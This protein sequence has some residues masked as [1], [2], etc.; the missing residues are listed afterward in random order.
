[1]TQGGLSCVREQAQTQSKTRISADLRMRRDTL[2]LLAA[3]VSEQ[4]VE[5]SLAAVHES[6][7]WHLTDLPIL[8]DHVRLARQTG[9][10]LN[11]LSISAD[12]Q[13]HQLGERDSIPNVR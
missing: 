10:H 5:R 8:H 11:L 13:R 4:Q 9:N 2:W 3:T 6:A 1:L 12:D 7:W